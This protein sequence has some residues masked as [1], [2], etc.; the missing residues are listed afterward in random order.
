MRHGELA[1]E[2]RIEEVEPRGGLGQAELVASI[3]LKQTAATQASMPTQAGGL[4]EIAESRLDV[5]E[6]LG[7]VGLEQAA[8][9]EQQHGG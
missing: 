5:G 8:L 1:L 7:G 9:V 6:V 3:V 4:A 2:A